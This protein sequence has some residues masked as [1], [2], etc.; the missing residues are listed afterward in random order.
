MEEKIE[1]WYRMGLWTDAMVREAVA[2]GIL[3][4]EE[5]ARILK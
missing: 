1:R 3:T 2:K 4:A 5:S